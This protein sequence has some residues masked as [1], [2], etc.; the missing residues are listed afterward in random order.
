[1]KHNTLFSEIFSRVVDGEINYKYIL[2][3]SPKIV[4][5]LL[6][7]SLKASIL[8]TSPN[9]NYFNSDIRSLYAQNPSDHATIY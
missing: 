3:H 1:M 9:K 7:N 6:F 8:K 2:R 4:P 5:K